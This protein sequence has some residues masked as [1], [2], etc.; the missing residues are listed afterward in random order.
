MSI[1]FFTTS[2]YEDIL[3]SSQEIEIGREAPPALEDQSLPWNVSAS[4][5]GSRTGS[6]AR[7][8]GLQSSTGGFPASAGR[9]S[10]FSGA[11]GGAPGSLD[12]RISRVT[13]AS[14]LFGRGIGRYSSLELPLHEETGV[15]LTGRDVSGFQEAEDFQLYRPAADVST[16]DAAQSQWMRIALNQES[17]N[18]LD[19]VKS[20]IESTASPT[21]EEEQDI[22]LRN[23][24]QKSILFEDLLP[25]SRHTKMVAAQGLL[26]VLTLA[27]KGLLN[28]WQN[29]SYGSITI[30]L[31]A[32]L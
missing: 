7:G 15:V 14:P 18:F 5:G 6:T 27:T 16:Q 11:T 32:G 30:S 21:G 20:Q 28:V 31:P 29:S 22:I 3:N 12:R 8:Y 4:A 25:C 17:N 19:F 2:E 13:S 1:L 26:H 24:S 9:P 23:T 10:S